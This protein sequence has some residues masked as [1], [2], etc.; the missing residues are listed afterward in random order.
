MDNERLVKLGNSLIDNLNADRI[1]PQK[2]LLETASIIADGDEAAKQLF[3]RL[4][5]QRGGTSAANQASG[6]PANPE[7]QAELILRAAEKGLGLGPENLAKINGG[8]APDHETM[9]AVLADT[10][11]K[12]KLQPQLLEHFLGRKTDKYIELL[13]DFLRQTVASRAEDPQE[14]IL[15][16]GMYLLFNGAEPDNLAALG[17]AAPLLAYLT[18]RIGRVRSIYYASMLFM[19]SYLFVLF[20]QAFE[21]SGKFRQATPD[22][23]LKLRKLYSGEDRIA[24]LVNNAVT[25]ASRKLAPFKVD[26]RE[27]LTNFK[28]F[29]ASH[30]NHYGPADL[31][32]SDYRG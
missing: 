10:I 4:W 26:A 11:V 13:K 17:L 23:Q 9:R 19:H 3:M 30:K 24:V 31:F 16:T 27:V 7:A 12:R 5:E 32:D 8:R 29:C 2:L 1:I 28:N 20:A 6:S 22:Q 21:L 18:D 25:I 14:L 15:Y